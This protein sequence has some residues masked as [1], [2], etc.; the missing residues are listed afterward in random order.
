MRHW[1]RAAMVAVCALAGIVRAEPPNASPAGPSPEALGRRDARSESSGMLDYLN[2]CALCHGR[3][4]QA[5]PL[6]TLQKLTPEKIYETI[7]TGEM[8]AQAAKLTE[9]QK[10]KVAE[11]LGGRRLLQ[12]ESG[13]AKHMSNPCVSNRPLGDFASMPAWN[14]WS[15]D[16][17]SNTRFQPTSAA[18]LS[19]AA[20]ARLKLKWALGLPGASSVYMQPISV[21]GRVFFGSDAGYLYSADALTGCV[22]W[23]F[24][25][26]AG[27]RST[28]MIAPVRPGSM[29]MAAFFGDIRGHVY[30]VDART[31]ALL[32]EVPV[33]AQPLSRVTA[34]VKVYEGR[35]YVP[36]SS[37]EEPAT[38]GYDYVCCTTRGMVVALDATTG[39]ELWKTYTISEPATSR[40][41][42]KGVKF[43]GPSG[44]NVWGTV[45]LDPKRRTLYLGTGNAF[46]EPDV[47]RSDA[48]MALDMDT[49]KI[50]WV[51]QVEH[52]DV[53][54]GLC[55]PGP[56]P[57]GIP[58]RSAGEPSPTNT[59]TPA[60][61]VSPGF[62][63]PP[64]YYCADVTHNPDYD[65]AAGPI[66]VDLP[67]GKSLIVAGQKSGV[68]WAFDPDRDGELVWKSDISRGEI[69]FGGAADEECGY[70]AMRGGAL[71]AVRLKDGLERWATLIDPQPSMV[72]HRGVSAAVSEI[73]GVVFV[74]GLDG[75]LH[76]YS[77][78]DG[79]PLWQYDTTQPVQTVNGVAGAGGSIGSAG[80]VIVGGMVYV[81]SGYIGFEAGQ[82]GNLLL[83]FGAPDP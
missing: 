9:D 50:R 80:A 83:A 71:A 37:L 7:S 25:A 79:R 33:D 21:D 23:S 41:T 3:I 73:P 12:G 75:V 34:A 70:F 2:T 62:A 15:P 58:P 19:P 20:T 1:H 32:W 22:Y 51:H 81:T 16:A 18:E 48:V 82:P 68:V 61:T 57:P 64:N 30:S 24:R 6:P 10:V 35:V 13:D 69:D 52:D 40:K 42:T 45:A 29:Q 46:S 67:S 28:P 14:G 47:G 72:S 60:A 11:W 39:R 43:L 38:V 78:F 26:Q 59:Q 49:G 74:A 56:P 76:A 5:P 44:A 8:K 65:F 4:A 54:H 63:R 17:L 27:L 31:G 77:T 55:P 53:W 66:L 36:V